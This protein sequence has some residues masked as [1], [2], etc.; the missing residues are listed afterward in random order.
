MD[1]LKY[2]S[3]AA[4]P[5]LPKPEP[6]MAAVVSPKGAPALEKALASDLPA[7][8][9]CRVEAEANVYPMVPAGASLTEMIQGLA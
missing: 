6:K 4:T 3:V 5:K 2:G 1:V 8:V 9:E 7:V